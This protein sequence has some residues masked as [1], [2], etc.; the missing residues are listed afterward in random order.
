MDEIMK[1]YKSRKNAKNGFY[2]I[3]LHY[4]VDPARDENWAEEMRKK[5]GAR[6]FAISH[7]LQRVQMGGIGVF[8]DLYRPEEHELSTYVGPSPRFGPVVLGWDFGGNHSVAVMQRQGREI[9]VLEEFPNMGFGTKDISEHI[10]DHLREKWGHMSLRY[11]DAIDPAGKDAGKET[12][13][14]SCADMLVAQA[15]SMGRTSADVKIP[16]TNLIKP[17]LEAVREVLRGDKFLLKLNPTCPLLRKALRGAYCWPENI[18]KG[19]KPEP[20][21]NSFSHI[22]DA[23]GYGIMV[24][25]KLSI[26]ETSY[27]RGGTRYE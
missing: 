1:G 9:I 24:L 16:K 15:K 2:S 20:E 14:R 4:S 25:T 3:R 21:K 8:S 7:D 19:R 10:Y 27:V 17:R 26:I 18:A 6:D 5:I 22:T 23:M 12:D 13:A 11:I